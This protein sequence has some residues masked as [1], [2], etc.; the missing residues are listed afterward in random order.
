VAD[1]VVELLTVPNAAI[2]PP[3]DGVSGGG[4]SVSGVAR[5]GERLIFIFELERL[6]VGTAVAT[7]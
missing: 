6:Y 1:A 2:S 5:A 3:D 7:A 4:N